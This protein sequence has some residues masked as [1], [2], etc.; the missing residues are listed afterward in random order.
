MIRQNVSGLAA[1]SRANLLN[2]VRF[3][4]PRL[5]GETGFQFF[6]IALYRQFMG[7]YKS[8]SGPPQFG[9]LQNINECRKI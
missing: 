9:A 2:R 4:T 7:D 1:G 3:P 6:R 5:S 8:K